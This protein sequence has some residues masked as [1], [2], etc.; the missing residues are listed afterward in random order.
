[1]NKYIQKI[2]Y[3]F[4][5]RRTKESVYTGLYHTWDDAHQHSSKQQGYADKHYDKRSLRKFTIDEKHTSG[6]NMIVPIVLAAT[7]QESQTILDI[8]GGV[9]SIFSHLNTTQKSTHRCYVLERPEIIDAFNAKIPQQYAEHLAYISSVD[10]LPCDNID[11]VYFGSSIQYIPEYKELLLNL[12][13]FNPK[14]IIFSESVFSKLESDIWVLQ[15]NMKPNIFPNLFIA[16]EGFLDFMKDIGY[17]C[18]LNIT[19]PAEHSH[20]QIDR[21]QYECKTL[22]FKS[23]QK[24]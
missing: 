4:Q 6:R 3:A 10:E 20:D 8:G 9:N 14:F 13:H 7:H 15:Q 5:G 21:G 23:S 1:M 2:K 17:D 12:K 19:I 24:L 11:I 16:E 18:T 22:I